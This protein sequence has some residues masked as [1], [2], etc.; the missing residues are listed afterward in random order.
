[1]LLLSTLNFVVQYLVIWLYKMIQTLSKCCF[2]GSSLREGGEEVQAIK[3]WLKDEK[4]T[5]ARLLLPHTLLNM[6]D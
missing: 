3:T 5:S 6:S 1:M 2:C 4:D